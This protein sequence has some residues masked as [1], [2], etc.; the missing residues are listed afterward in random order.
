MFSGDGLDVVAP[1]VVLKPSIEVGKRII[2]IESDR[3][4]KI[5]DRFVV[6]LSIKRGQSA[7]KVNLRFDRWR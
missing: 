7:V 4:G 1:I 5:A 6:L 2:W 3:L